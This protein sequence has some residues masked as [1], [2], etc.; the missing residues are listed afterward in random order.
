MVQAAIPRQGIVT[1][2]LLLRR[3][4]QPRSPRIRRFRPSPLRLFV[5]DQA[6]AIQTPFRSYVLR[7]IHRRAIAEIGSS[8]KSAEVSTWS[9]PDEPGHP[10]L[11]L[12][13][14][15]GAKRSELNRVRKVMLAEIAEA[16]LRWTDSQRSDYSE[17]IYFELGTANT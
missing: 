5:S 16:A 17:R 8:L 4:L 7:T 6:K 13:I 15:A 14:I 2:T 10:I 3:T 12:T 1:R 9:Q 11:L